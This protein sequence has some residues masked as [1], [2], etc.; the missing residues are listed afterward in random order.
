METHEKRKK[1]KARQ[2]DVHGNNQIS[3][4]DTEKNYVKSKDSS[5]TKRNKD[6][7]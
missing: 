5:K 7:I 3:I 2:E 1:M 6:V 4:K